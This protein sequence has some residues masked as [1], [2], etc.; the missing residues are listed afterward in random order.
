MN[1]FPLSLVKAVLHMNRVR[2]E[3]CLCVRYSEKYGKPM[4]H[5]MEGWPHARSRRQLA[6]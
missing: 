6:R 1:T 2:N 4:V 3:C 5:F